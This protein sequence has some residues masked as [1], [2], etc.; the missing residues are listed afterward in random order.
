M[1]PRPP[2]PLGASLDGKRATFCVWAPRAESVE[3]VLDGPRTET[4]AMSRQDDYFTLAVDDVEAGQRYG[5]RIDGGDV[6]PDPATRFQPDGVHG[7]S[8]VQPATFEWSSTD[9]NGLPLH[10]YVL[11]EMHVG[12]FTPAGTFDAAARR[13]PD[14]QALGIT[15]I[16]L[17]PLSQ[18]PGSRNWGYDGVHPYAVQNSYGGPDALKQFVDRCHEHGIGVCL[19]VVYNHLGPEGNRLSEFGPYFTDRYS[20]PWGDALNF[21][22]A[23]SDHVREYFI[24]SALQWIDEYRIDALRMDAIHAITDT[25]AYPFLRELADRIHE[26]ARSLGREVVLIAESDLG[27]P[28]VIR[29]PEQGGLGVDAQW[30]DDFHHALHT[31]LTGERDGYYQDFGSLEHLAR[32]YRR[33]FVYAGEYSTSRRRRHGTSADDVLPAR[34]VAFLQNHDQIGNRMKGDRLTEQLSHQQLRLGAAALLLSP[35]TPLLFMGEEYAETA[36]FPYFVSHT[37]EELIAAVRHG[38]A[39]E[40]KSFGWADEPPDPQAESTF[41]TAT[42]DWS[43]RQQGEHAD[44][45]SLY[46]ELLRARREMQPLRPQSFDQIATHVDPSTSTLRITF[47]TAASSSLLFLHFGDMPTDAELPPGNWRIR[48]NTAARRESDS[49]RA[50]QSLPLSPQSAVLLLR[51]DAA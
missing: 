28:R 31:V 9:W 17:M 30:L 35:F 27:D 18:F 32:A 13:L 22:G 38:R 11:Y 1:T 49:G 2:L 40:F 15:V 44:M 51:E 14:L 19:D 39:D 37:D 16:E 47:T 26:R 25:S 36:P 8:A 24:Q 48:V 46:T 7:L 41:E 12:C 10:E 3:L 50:G 6:L 45:Y 29:P 21:D 34:F 43:L 5:F 33:G 20:T 23:D 42:L 4:H